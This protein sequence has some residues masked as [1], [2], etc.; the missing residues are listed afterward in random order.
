VCMDREEAWGE[1]RGE[2]Y[3]KEIV[4]SYWG[5]IKIIISLA[6]DCHS[7]DGTAFPEEPF[8]NR[9]IGETIH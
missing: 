9:C 8:M 3:I 1:R 2:L 4:T 7:R 6:I 5:T